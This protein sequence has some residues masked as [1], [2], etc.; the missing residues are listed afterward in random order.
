MQDFALEPKRR[1]RSVSQ[2]R[3]VSSFFRIILLSLLLGTLM[4]LD[5]ILYL[6]AGSVF[7][8]ASNVMLPII[9]IVV[10]C[11]VFSAILIFFTSFS[12]FIRSL[13]FGLI[14]ALLALAFMNQFLQIDKSQYL[15]VLLTSFTGNDVFIKLLGNFSHWILLA[16]I[17]LICYKIAS[18]MSN[19]SLC[20]LVLILLFITGGLG[21]LMFLSKSSEA[22]VNEV[23]TSTEKGF[24]ENKK[25]TIFL[26]MPNAISYNALSISAQQPDDVNTLL[27]N[28]QLGFFAKYGFKLYP[29][30]YLANSSQDV[31]LIELLNPLDVKSYDNH[32]LNNVGLEKL[33]K[34]KSSQKTELFLKD[35]QLID[36]YK[37]AQYKTSAYQ[38]QHLELCKK[39]NQ[40][41]TDRCLSRTSAPFDIS[42]FSDFD[43]V[44]ILLSQWLSTFD[45]LYHPSIVSPI[46]LLLGR[47]F[48]DSVLL[49]YDQTYVVNSLD[50]LKRLLEDISSDGG[51]A[52][53]Y[54][55]YLDFPS[56]LFVFDEWCHIKPYNE[57]STDNPK[58]STNSLFQGTA[59]Y[60]R[61]MLCFWGYMEEFMA[62]LK[63]IEV[64]D[65]LTFV[66]QGIS[67]GQGTSFS[68]KN[69]ID[70]FKK[71]RTVLFAIRDP[72]SKF[73]VNNQICQSK[74]FLRS[75]LLNAPKCT[76]FSGLSLSAGILERIKNDLRKNVL[77]RQDV[78]KAV[79][80]YKNHLKEWRLKRKPLF[81]Q[82]K[83]VEVVEEKPEVPEEGEVLSD[84]AV[85]LLTDVQ[86]VSQPTPS[87]DQE[88][89][90]SSEPVSEK[91]DTPAVSPKSEVVETADE[92]PLEHSN[93]LLET[94]SEVAVQSVTE[95]KTEKLI[96]EEKVSE[97]KNE[98]ANDEEAITI[99]DEQDD[100]SSI[101][102]ADLMPEE[103]SEQQEKFIAPED[104]TNISSQEIMSEKVEE[105]KEVEVNQK[106][107]ATQVSQTLNNEIKQQEAAPSLNQK[108]LESA[109]EANV[110][111]TSSTES[112]TLPSQVPTSRSEEAA[113]DLN[114]MILQQPV[115]K[116]INETQSEAEIAPDSSQE[117]R[118]IS[119]DFLLEE[120]QEDEWEFDPAE[121]LGVSGEEESEDR[122]VVK[123][124]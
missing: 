58:L 25:K 5:F 19:A 100:L 99:D 72:K 119:G 109:S 46:Q 52:G 112:N 8:N 38:N 35:S 90:S 117:T 9:I 65:N 74:D 50:V 113:P 2:N 91:I 49:P 104:D 87:I 110:E 59:N 56:N 95:D 68:S 47:E 111:V 83:V 28:V 79:S 122:I 12:R 17:F 57:W 37:K 80:A 53:A 93:D 116:N 105:T 84:E 29:N 103:A 3:F 97:I 10:G 16:I 55:V 77:T 30:A 6:K 107:Q 96:N 94:T 54:F 32:I 70:K 101:E 23:Y 89:T 82:Q 64:L 121:A 71:G 41:I 88:A 39:N 22:Y 78:Q 124:K 118:P 42:Q 115:E 66:I 81:N 26:F 62:N 67:S 63:K 60:S 45:V 123:V 18:K 92:V 102:P 7:L 15:P 85:K 24:T 27:K 31:N 43:K 51:K 98:V 21:S 108:I 120:N 69:A 44:K 14:C 34:F 36:V 86:E 76:E 13:L 1:G 4:S 75:Y 114:R 73:G 11:F 106:S 61:Q 20:T 40:Y 33:W 48:L